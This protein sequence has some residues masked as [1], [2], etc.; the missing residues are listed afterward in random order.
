M[1]DDDDDVIWLGAL[2]L[3]R[4][5]RAGVVSAASATRA[6][7]DR[8]DA[9]NPHLEAF[10]TVTAERALREAAAADAEIAAGWWRGPLHGV[11]YCLKDIVQTAG[12]R[13]TAGSY[14]LADW[15]P[16]SD[17]TVQTR[18]SA[19]GA[20][21]L[22]K[23]NSHEFAFGTTTQNIH[24]RTRNP[25][26]PDRLPGGS[27]GGSAAAVAAGLAAFSIGSDTAGSIRMPAAFCGIA[28]LKPTY[29]LV[30]AAGVVAQSFTSD[31]VGPMARSVGDLTP[32][33]AAIAGP[34]AADPTSLAVAP[35]DF[36]A[37][38]RPALDG[39][40]VGI[41]VELMT[42]PLD[43]AVAAG[44]DRARHALEALG[45]RVAE[46]SVPLL[47]HAGEINGAIVPPETAAQHSRWREGWFRGRE[48]RYGEDVAALLAMGAAVPGTATILA[49]RDRI[50]L[51]RQLARV[52]ADRADILITPTEPMVAPPR[53]GKPPDLAAVTHFLCGFS[54]TGLPALALP[55]GADPQGLPVSVQ[56]VGPPLG[57]PRVLAVG[58]A[59]EA[60][61]GA[62]PR[63]FTG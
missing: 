37:I 39:L 50:A 41:P 54:L 9:L 62:C 21:L 63:P 42:I 36:L 29:G 55:C 3:G 60:A 14:I 19:A 31:H 59:L 49:Q 25:H 24:G 57:D 27:S 52:F 17:A 4:R 58:Q 15:M 33:M 23:V 26:D 46:L 5:I 51:G 47:A 2:E 56:I 43:P 38:G 61:I 34:D 1:S 8:I 18:L 20:V 35:A 7:L 6:F 40:R 16:D 30:S 28:G 11:P 10:V 53:D 13:T 48:I 22:G 44:F 32:I 45:A 12:I